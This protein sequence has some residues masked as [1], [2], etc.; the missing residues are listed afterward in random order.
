MLDRPLPTDAPDARDASR[1]AAP[2]TS[3]SSFPA[4]SRFDTV[5][6]ALTRVRGARVCIPLLAHP[7]RYSCCIARGGA[8]LARARRADAG[9]RHDA[10]HA[11]GPGP[12]GARSWWPHGLADILAGD[13]HGDDRS[14]A[15]GGSFLEPQDGAEQAELLTGSQSRRHPA[16]TSRCI[17][18]PPLR[19]R[20]SWMQQH[21]PPS[22]REAS[23]RRARSSAGLEALAA[24]PRRRQALSAGRAGG[25]GRARYAAVLRQGGTLFFCGNGGSAADAQHLAAEYVVRYAV[26]PPCLSPRSRSP[27]T[28]RCSPPRA[29]TSA[30]SRSSPGR[31]RRS[32]G[33]ATCWCCTAPAAESPNLLAAARAARDARGDHGRLPGRGRRA[34]WRG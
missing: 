14:I 24:L 17:P 32:A 12:A 29:T 4:W 19:I 28:P 21:P 16:T 34:R 8:P 22:R 1:S 27:P 6:N 31:S 26:T 33:R 18:V 15:A 3:W 25:V 20:R 11:A 7:E 23:D 9:G 2:A 13:N 30:S 5:T 10:A